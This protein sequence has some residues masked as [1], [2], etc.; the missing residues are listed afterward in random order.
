MNSQA[1]NSQARRQASLARGVAP[2]R[3]GTLHARSVTGAVK[4]PP[5]P[6]RTVRF[7]RGDTPEVDLGVG[8]HDL[9]VS[10][11][12]GE[13]TYRDRQWWLR[14]TGQQLV[15]LPRGRMMHASTEPLP[16]AP[17]YTPLFVRGSG[18]REHLVELYVTGHDDQGLVSRRGADTV[19][20]KRWSLEDDERLLLVVLG[21]EYLLYEERPRPLTYSRAAQLLVY[22]RP[23]GNWN[24]RKVEYRVD[25]VRHRLHETG[26]PH[27]LLHDKSAGR[28][29]DNSLLHNLLRGLV[30]STTL[31]PPDL[32]LMDDDL[33]DGGVGGMGEGG[34]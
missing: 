30:E 19:P 10:R 1:T 13:L 20:P 31:V 4:V 18:Y 5:R 3:P 28:P 32:C 26:F 21:Q 29:S 14:N 25:L 12:H 2:A 24:E 11:Q 34:D 22:L 17:G 23:D 15:R 27:P 8:E 6:G 7:G 33:D 9:M 16:L